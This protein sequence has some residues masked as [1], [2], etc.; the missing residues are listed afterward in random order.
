MGRYLRGIYAEALGIEVFE[1]ISPQRAD[2]L[3]HEKML[4]MFHDK[5]LDPL[6]E[7]MVASGLP[8]IALKL[9]NSQSVL[10]LEKK[11]EIFNLNKKG[12]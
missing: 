8:D 6:S 2:R 10:N 12:V 3:A 9:I 1:E 11:Q 4:A 7:K 5:T